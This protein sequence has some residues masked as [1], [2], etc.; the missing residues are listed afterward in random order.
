[1]IFTTPWILGLLAALPVLWYVLRVL[2]PPPRQIVFPPARFLE[3]LAGLPRESKAT[4]W[5]ILLLRLS[6]IACLIIGLAG[7]VL[8]PPRKTESRRHLTLL[9]DNGWASAPNWREEIAQA[10]DIVENA[11]PD[12]AITIAASASETH[13]IDASR[14]RALQILNGMTPMPWK[15]DGGG[16]ATVLKTAPGSGASKIFYFSDG[17]E[18]EAIQRLLN[19]KKLGGA[20]LYYVPRPEKM[21]VAISRSGTGFALTGPPDTQAGAPYKIQAVDV[22]N[23]VKSEFFVSRPAAGFPASFDEDIEKLR[24]AEVPGAGS[25]YGLSPHGKPKRIGI[26]SDKKGNV[27]PLIDADYFLERVARPLGGLIE[28]ELKDILAQH[29]SMIVMADK[30]GLTP[31]Q[32]G[33]LKGWIQKG[34]LLL[35]F[36]GP[37]MAADETRLPDLLPIRIR[38]GFKAYDAQISSAKNPVLRNFSMAGPLADIKIAEPISI[39]RQIL[40]DPAD[41]TVF[42]KTWASLGDGTPLITAARHGEGWVVFIQTSAE[43]SWSDLPL[44]GV[45]I[46][47]LDH[48]ATLSLAPPDANIKVTGFMNPVWVWDGFGNQARMDETAKPIAAEDFSSTPPSRDHP[49][50]LYSNGLFSA[51]LNIGDHAPILKSLAAPSSQILHYGIERG[52]NL[53]PLFLVLA[54]ILLAAD[55]LILL[56]RGRGFKKRQRRLPVLFF[57]LVFFAP[58]LG[59]A[60]PAA[61]GNAAYASALYLAYMG[62]GDGLSDS[63]M[64]SGLEHLRDALKA[65]TAVEPAGVVRADP[66][67]D[68]LAFFPL[69]YWQMPGTPLRLSAKALENIRAYLAHGGTI[70]FDSAGRSPMQAEN[71]RNILG[72]LDAPPLERMPTD[73]VL[74]R[75]YYLLRK[76]DAEDDIW[77][78]HKDS[79]DRD[80]VSSIIIGHAGWAE[81]WKEARGDLSVSGDPSLRFGINLAIYAL[82]GN[83]KSD[84]IHV[85]ALLDRMG[86]P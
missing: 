22:Q 48:L 13:A 66:E 37:R 84:Q 2:P 78:E 54:L 49:P 17:L 44:N 32:D 11:A 68:I 58:L 24:I 69:I 74:R 42:E 61:S 63:V 29:P 73:H 31:E 70:F 52:K 39:R 33:L 7:P 60:E 28:G 27:R 85:R 38:P 46:D 80:G 34:G 83:Y 79:E 47:I 10:K 26:I 19:E 35:R 81:Q 18:H 8:D 4:P 20:A 51:Y 76:L 82:T 21:P 56:S 15:G 75:S 59:R 12:A 45:F 30:A 64:R 77:T 36:A 72:A 25:V 62:N 50:G 65:R 53:M 16:I 9:I 3:G 23:R 14:D 1:M 67:Q 6:A 86:R 57:I 5:H 55:W 43:P 41:E 71:L 40:A